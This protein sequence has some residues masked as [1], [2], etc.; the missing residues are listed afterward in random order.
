[1]AD[2]ANA[3]EVP[4][5]D[6]PTPDRQSTTTLNRNGRINFINAG[7]KV[8]NNKE[9]RDFSGE[10]KDVEA[11][12][13]LVTKQVDKGVTF[14]RFQETLKNY[15]LKSL[16]N[17]EDMV[18]LVMNLKYPTTTFKSNHYLVDLTE[19]QLKSP[20][21]V[22]MW[23]LFIKYYLSQEWKLWGNVHKLYMIVLVQC[24]QSL[25]QTFKGDPK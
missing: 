1:M 22:K 8:S 19:E 13:T 23:E 21:K 17:G 14:E 20:I 10:T 4:R 25:R 16:E 7:S 24:T 11:I 3:D 5:T 2:N 18:P 15:V 6:S 12:F 9:I